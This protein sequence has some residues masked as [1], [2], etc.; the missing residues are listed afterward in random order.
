M[1]ARV[2]QWQNTTPHSQPAQLQS[3]LA[4]ATR[5]PGLVVVQ[6]AQVD[7]WEAANKFLHVSDTER[8]ADS[9]NLIRQVAVHAVCIERG[10][11]RQDARG[12]EAQWPRASQAPDTSL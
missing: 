2:L 9:R 7:G 12:V 8:L 4:S 3:G 6:I 5:Y 1:T 11:S 10:V